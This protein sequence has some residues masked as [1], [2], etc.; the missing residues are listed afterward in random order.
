MSKMFGYVDASAD[1]YH[2]RCQGHQSDRG[3]LLKFQDFAFVLLC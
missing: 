2:G 1:K 3:M